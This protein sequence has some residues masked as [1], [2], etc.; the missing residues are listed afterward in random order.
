MEVTS[1]PSRLHPPVIYPAGNIVNEFLFRFVRR[2]EFFE[3]GGPEGF[4]HHND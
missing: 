3:P 4:V 2:R 1:I